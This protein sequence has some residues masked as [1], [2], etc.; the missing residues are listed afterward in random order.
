MLLDS[1]LWGFGSPGGEVLVPSD[2]VLGEQRGADKDMASHSALHMYTW[3][4]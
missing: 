1:D 4:K 3:R 2:H